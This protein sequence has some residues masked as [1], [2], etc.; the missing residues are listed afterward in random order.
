VSAAL[1]IRGLVKRYDT[2]AGPVEVLRGVDLDLAPGT[3]AAITGPSGCGKSTLLHVVGGLDAPTAGTVR[4]GDVDPYALP[5]PELARFRNRSIGFVFQD[6]HLLPQ[7]DVLENVLV[8]TLAFG[9]PPAG[10]DERA[11]ELLD[12]VGL[13]HRLRHRPSQLSGGERQ[14]AAVARAMVANP[15]LL[16]CDEPT[17]SLDPAS[18]DAVADLLFELQA[19]RDTLLVVVTHSADLAGRFERRVDLREGRC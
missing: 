4:L 14:R 8:P 12:R 5:E 13:G 3:R 15:D 2:E 9:D 18:A 7:F 19:E 10:V 11:R 16:L 1:E 17:G 6:S